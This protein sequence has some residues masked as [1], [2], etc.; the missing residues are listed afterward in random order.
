MRGQSGTQGAAFGGKSINFLD[1]I[2]GGGNQYFF[3]GGGCKRG[4]QEALILSTPGA[5]I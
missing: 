3:L 5:I 2:W 4:V 1:A